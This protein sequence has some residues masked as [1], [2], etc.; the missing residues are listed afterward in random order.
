MLN[1]N[2]V[3]IDTNAAYSISTLLREI[4]PL[5]DMSSALMALAAA[6]AILAIVL[7]VI[8]G[9]VDVDERDGKIID[10]ISSVARV[11]VFVAIL[12]SLGPVA[13][14][15]LDGVG[16]DSHLKFILSKVS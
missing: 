6:S 13:N 15:I 2:A 11:L 4:S 9:F 1:D 12:A 10:T 8:R 7:T 3:L 16:A 14:W 5:W